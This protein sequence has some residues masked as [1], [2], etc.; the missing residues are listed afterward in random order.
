VRARQPRREA[1]AKA[2]RQ[3]RK[4]GARLAET[5]AELESQPDEWKSKSKKF[6]DGLISHY[7]LDDGKLVVAHAGLK[8]DMQGRGSG[9][10]RAFCLYGETTGETDEFGLPVRYPWASEYRGNA[11][12]V[13]GHT[14]VPQAEWLNRTINIDTG[15]VFGGKLTAL[16]YPELETVAVDAAR[17]YAE[18][19][20][21][22]LPAS[23]HDGTERTAQQQHDDVLDIADVTGKRI[24][25]T[26]LHPS[27]TIR[28]ENSIAALEVMSRF[29]A[30]PRWLIYLPPTMSPTE[31][32][33]EEGLLEHPREA[34]DYY[35]KVGVAQVVCEEKTHGFTRAVVVLCRDEEAAR[36]RFGVSE[37]SGI[38]Y[39]RTGRR[40]FSDES[41]ENQMLD[42]PANR[43]GRRWFLGRVWNRLGVSRLRTHAVVGQSAGIAAAPVCSG[44]CRIAALVECGNTSTRNCRRT[45]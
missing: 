19:A 13:Y 22:F 18:P 6:L 39:T 35:A 14:P 7:V 33:R 24:V 11:M 3:R 36:R 1:V 25:Q 12:V 15:C 9:A 23:T 16:R 26:R 43:A 42:A 10:V 8:Q 32:S 38:C 34:F 30:D 28:E 37:G 20:R 31:T 27:I 21:P 40:F 2:E 17:T 45:R 41:L 4:G 5:L 44:R 29:A